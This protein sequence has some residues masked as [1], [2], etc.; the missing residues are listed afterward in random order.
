MSVIAHFCCDT[1]V[2]NI[3]KAEYFN[4]LTCENYICSVFASNW[5][6]IYLKLLDTGF[7]TVIISR[8]QKPTA[9]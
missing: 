9:A 4:V 2:D 3:R 1:V 6:G 7:N 5:K 8:F